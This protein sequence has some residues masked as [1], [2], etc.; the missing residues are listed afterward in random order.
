[1]Q[2]K[3]LRVRQMWNRLLMQLSNRQLLLQRQV[4][5]MM[6]STASRACRSSYLLRKFAA[7][8]VMAC[9]TR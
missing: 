7:A 2:L 5:Q 1:M 4:R 8:S 6:D 9:A 3:L